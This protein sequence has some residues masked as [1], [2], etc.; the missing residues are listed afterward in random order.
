M[1]VT[2]VRMK[3]LRNKIGVTQAQL[4]EKLDVTNDTVSRWERGVLE[5]GRDSLLRLAAALDTSVAYLIGETEDSSPPK[6]LLRLHLSGPGIG[7]VAGVVSK[8]GAGDEGSLGETDGPSPPGRPKGESGDPPANP[9]EHGPPK[10]LLNQAAL[11]DLNLK[12]QTVV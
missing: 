9:V 8:G 10:N 5:I 1:D 11:K 6:K 4:A 7:A 12:Y 3:E 2:G